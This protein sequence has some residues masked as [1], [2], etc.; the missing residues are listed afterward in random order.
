MPKSYRN[1]RQPLNRIKETQKGNPIEFGVSKKSKA[2]LLS[3]ET[4]L[5]PKTLIGEQFT[6]NHL[7]TIKGEIVENYLNIMVNYIIWISH[8]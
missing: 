1:K 7:S 5:A 4:T 8:Q 3:E 6:S 2:T